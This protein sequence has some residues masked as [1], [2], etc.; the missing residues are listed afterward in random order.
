M[1]SNRRKVIKPSTVYK[2]SDNYIQ[3]IEDMLENGIHDLS[4]IDIPSLKNIEKMY[5]I[6]FPTFKNCNYVKKKIYKKTPNLKFRILNSELVYSAADNTKIAK[7]TCFDNMKI[8]NFYKTKMSCNGENI[9]TYRYGTDINNF[10]DIKDFEHVFRA[11]KGNTSM[12]FIN[13]NLMGLCNTKSCKRIS[14]LKLPKVVRD[15]LRENR[16][17][18]IEK[19][20]NRIPK[21]NFKFYTLIF[22][23][24]PQSFFN[25]KIGDPTLENLHKT[26]DLCFN[27][28][29]DIV[30]KMKLSGSSMFKI[31]VDIFVH[32]YFNCHKT[33]NLGIHCKSG[34]DRTSI[35][36]A[37]Q[38]ATFYYLMNSRSNKIDYETIRE[39]VP[40]YLIVG[41]VIAYRSTGVIGIK[42]KRLPLAK[43]ILNKQQIDFFAGVYI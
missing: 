27:D 1:L 30:H 2:I 40:Y 31:I 36:D 32:Y 23:V 39:F 7:G 29:L 13:I 38:K 26:D 22:P 28:M 10:N 43:F 8:Y 37:I 11:S 42:L 24:R 16:I 6:K 15:S 33:H 9:V 35:I 21:N 41:L 12:P 4:I 19:N 3:H 17:I 25:I 34:K 5:G 20:S 14:N 18:D